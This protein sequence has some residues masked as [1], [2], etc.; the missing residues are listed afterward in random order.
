MKYFYLILLQPANPC[1]SIISTVAHGAA[2]ERRNIMYQ[3]YEVLRNDVCDVA[4]DN[5]HAKLDD[6]IF[7]MNDIARLMLASRLRVMD[8]GGRVVAYIEQ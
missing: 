6:A 3:V 1:N 8:G 5:K 4:S 7:E 2:R